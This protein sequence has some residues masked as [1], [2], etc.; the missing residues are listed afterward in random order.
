MTGL[1]T[2][3][4]P[5]VDQAVFRDVVGHFTSGVTVITTRHGGEQFGVTASA[6]SSLSMDPPM[7]LVC[8][9]RRLPTNEAV[10]S[11][12]VFAVNI[13]SEDQGELAT[14]FATRHPDKF[15]DVPLA[16][17]RLGVPVL[18]DALASLECSVRECVD[19]ATHSVFFAEV[20]RAHAT[21]GSPLA[22]YRGNFGRFAE[23]LDDSVYRELRERVLSRSLP[24]DESITV[25]GMADQL[26]VGRAPVF[27]A[28]EQLRSDGLLTPHPDRG[29]TVTPITVASAWEAYDARASI[30]CG[31]IDQVGR[32]L[33]AEQL[34]R[35]RAAAEGTLPWIRGGRFIDVEGYVTANAAF[36]ETL[37]DLAGNSALL[38]AYRRLALPTVMSK[39]LHGVEETLDRF[40]ADHVAVVELLQE[41]DIEGARAL[42]LEHTEAGKERM[43]IAITRTGGS[44]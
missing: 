4:A 11:S 35:L 29:Y 43:R 31:V 30:E 15:R 16:E 1:N 3:T 38:V 2:T 42:V 8:L 18:A 34:T 17:D 19:V 37:V 10:R 36:H 26:D 23:A 12:G 21:P 5:C 41:G 7:L 32:T 28:L 22:Y 6:V 20:R 14:Q 25:D 24:L 44:Y 40:S 9:N 13:L 39:A 27:R 33:T